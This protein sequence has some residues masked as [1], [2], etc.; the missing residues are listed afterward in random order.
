MYQVNYKQYES[1]GVAT[2][3]AKQICRERPW[4]Y[5]VIEE[6]E[7][8]V[9]SVLLLVD[10]LMASNFGSRGEAGHIM[11][12]PRGSVWIDEETG[13]WNYEGICK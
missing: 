8:T 5:V 9:V 3:A 1:L 7:E 10:S 6:D 12:T 4:S 2:E 11:W 13:E